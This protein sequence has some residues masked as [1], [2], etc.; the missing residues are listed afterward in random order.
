MKVN[1]QLKSIPI[2]IIL[3][4]VIPLSINNQREKTKLKILIW[5]TPSLSLG[6]YLAISTGSGFLL[7]CL[8]TGGLIQVN[9]SKTINKIKYK[10]DNQ[11]DKYSEY[12]EV[13]NFSQYDN[14]LIERDIKDPSPT[15]NANFRVIGKIS[16][17]SVSHNNNERDNFY[18]SDSS[19]ESNDR[20]Y[21]NEITYEKESN[22]DKTLN[23]WFDN[24]HLDW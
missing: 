18:S 6:T 9:K 7:S 16:R 11:D 14:T 24:N 1:S 2:L 15:L 4:L 19:N 23:D 13:S 10:V 17:K 21:E 12:S 5:D 22:S 3:I 8:I 20:Y